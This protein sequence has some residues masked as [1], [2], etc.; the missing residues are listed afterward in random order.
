MKRERAVATVLRT[1]LPLAKVPES[2]AGLDRAISLK[3]YYRDGDGVFSCRQLARRRF[4]QAKRK[5]CMTNTVR[6]L[7]QEKAADNTSANTIE[8]VRD[9]LFGE[10][11]REHD[12]RI[13]DL[14]LSIKNMHSHL[15]E[16]LR[17][18]EAKMEAMSQALT[19]RQEESLRK[20]GEAIMSVGRQISALGSSHEH[21]R[22]HKA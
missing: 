16:Q 9:L 14:D 5:P 12:G 4:G 22:D 20:I 10:A 1:P 18:M 6:F 19:S 13:A 15:D 11:K 7:P 8:Q 21:D 3:S 2:A 17:S